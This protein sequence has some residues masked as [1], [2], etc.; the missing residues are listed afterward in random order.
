MPTDTRSKPKGTLGFWMCTALVVGNMI[1]SGIF[2]LPSSLAVFGPISMAGWVLTAGGAI[3]LALIFGRLA[4]LSSNTGGPYAYAREGF[5]DFAGF[6]IAWGYWIA[7]WSGNAAVAVAF[8]GYLSFMVPAIG[9]TALAGLAVS[10]GAIWLLTWVNLRGV[11]Q[12]GIVQVVTTVMK[13]APLLV[14]ILLGLSH[15]Q[16]ANFRPA[17]L[18]GMSNISAI[19]ACA[20]LTLWAFVGLESAT[21]PAGDVRNPTKTIPLA[22]IVGTCVAALVYIATTYVALGV[23]PSGTL[24]G[25]NAPL[26]DV[27]HVMWGFGGAVFI[28]VGACVSTFGTLNGF[29]LLTGQVP[30]GAARDGLFPAGFARVSRTG[31]PA[32][33]LISSSL[34]ASAL[35]AMNYTRSLAEQFEF[36]ILLATLSTLVPY[37][38]CAGAEIMIRAKR[39]ERTRLPPQAFVLAGL[40]FVY[41]FWAIFGAGKDVVFWG[42]LLLLAGLP[43][44]VWLRWQ[45]GA[46]T[47]KEIS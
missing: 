7:L 41:S 18:S 30:L 2:L 21:V 35:I 45:S 6:L 24:A 44:H 13:L 19:S 10:L 3:V 23:V 39:K 33:G 47:S 1:G 25:S 8:A 9:E 38:L 27:A 29:V 40:G 42:V 16:P 36:I 5:G 12:A 11:R 34:L 37:L 17:N 15:V 31:T 43:I 14:L 28:A 22:T 32:F 20:A 46:I 26:A 4:R